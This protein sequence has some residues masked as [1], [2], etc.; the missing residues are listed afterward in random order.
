MQ[1]LRHYMVIL[2]VICHIFLRFIHIWPGGIPALSCF[3]LTVSVAIEKQESSITLL[4]YTQSRAGFPSRLRVPLTSLPAQNRLH[5]VNTSLSVDTDLGFPLLIGGLAFFC[6]KGLKGL[7]LSVSAY[8]LPHIF[9][10][11]LTSFRSA[12]H[13]RRF[14]PRCS[15]TALF[16]H[17]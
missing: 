16:I 13:V 10:P 14:R 11:L 15:C 12:C 5:S 17:Y 4:V 1:H 3:S 6:H 7:P 2:A 9:L 8:G